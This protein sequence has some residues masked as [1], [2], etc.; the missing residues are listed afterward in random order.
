MKLHFS[1]FFKISY[2]VFSV[3]YIV[4]SNILCLNPDAGNRTSSNSYKN[5]ALLSFGSM[6]Y[7][8]NLPPMV[9]ARYDHTST[10]LS[11]GRVLIAGGNPDSSAAET[12]EPQLDSFVASGSLSFNR[13]YHTANLLKSGRVILIGGANSTGAP[14]ISE[15]YLPN[16]SS[17]TNGP[18]FTTQRYGHTSTEL[19]NG[20][21]LIA[22]GISGPS[23]LT[24]IQIY[25]QDTNTVSTSPAVL[26][27]ARGYHT[28]TRLQ[29]GKVL[30]TGGL[31][32][33]TSTV[34]SSME[35]FDPDTNTVNDAGSMLSPRNYHTASL[36]Q[37]GSVFI[38]GGETGDNNVNFNEVINPTTFQSRDVALKSS[39]NQHSGIVTLSGSVLS[40]GGRRYSRPG[41]VNLVNTGEVYDPIT[42]ISFV[43]QRMSTPRSRVSGI[44][45]NSG[46]FSSRA[47]SSNPEVPL[48]PLIFRKF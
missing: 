36:L 18:D 47:V 17:F 12:Y 4:I 40:I 22:G 41:V 16:S 11:D 21:I 9:L 37:D 44:R 5:L 28:A 31:N 24:S 14:T 27:N 3:L 35:L 38:S 43:S 32:S 19:I 46:G 1:S 10:V 33:A 29:N 2:R 30:F 8:R 25:D 6:G 23:S 45:L 48:L 20:K 39:R 34:L 42:G 26:K 7:I 13:R 15:I